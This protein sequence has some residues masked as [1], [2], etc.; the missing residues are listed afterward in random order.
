MGY[1]KII[2]LGADCNYVDMVDGAKK[3]GNKLVM[4]K[5]PEKNPNYAWDDYNQKGDEYNIP[6][7]DVFQMPGWKALANYC[8]AHGVQVV[9]CS[10]ESK[11]EYFRKNTL[12]RELTLY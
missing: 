4:E 12:E 5:T 2:L 7:A 1:K 10:M 11:I 3:V 9:N 6:R 8:A